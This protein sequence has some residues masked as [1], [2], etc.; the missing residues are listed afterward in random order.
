MPNRFSVARHNILVFDYADIHLR[1]AAYDSLFDLTRQCLIE[2]QV[3]RTA[4]RMRNDRD[5]AY[6]VDKVGPAEP[7]L[8]FWQ[9]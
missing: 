9:Q 8:K 6:C 1:I 2:W 4:S 7:E 3:S 5:Q